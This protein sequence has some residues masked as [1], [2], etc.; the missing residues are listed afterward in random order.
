MKLS[1]VIITYNRAEALDQCLAS[2]VDQSFKKFEVIIVDGNS[3]DN[4]NQ[5]IDS[6]YHQLDIKKHINETPSIAKLRDYGWRRASG[7]YIAWIDDDVVT[8]PGWAEEI[9]STLDENKSIGGVSGPTLVRKELI[10]NRDVFKLYNQN[11]PIAKLWKNFFL[12]GKAH[13]PGL[14]LKNGW[15]T[16]GSNFPSAKE[17][18]GLKEVDYLEPCNMTY[19]RKLVKEVNG[20]DHDYYKEQSETDIAFRIR[21]LGVKLAF[22]PQAVVY[23]NISQAGSYSGRTAAK[24]RMIDFYRF[25]FRHVYQPKYIFR[26]LAIVLFQNLYYTYKAISDRNLSWLGSWLGSVIGFEFLFE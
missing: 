26:F 24:E 12:E 11:G 14:I 6:Y 9:V 13:Q 2:L 1:I 20:F 25:Y 3:Q 16:P 18:K 17:I 8:T 23:H 21:N 15:W 22:N 10:K 19:R 4:T 5:V 7:R